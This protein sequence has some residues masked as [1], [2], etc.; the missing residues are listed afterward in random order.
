MKVR[1]PI[2]QS[3]PFMHRGGRTS[4]RIVCT[5][6]RSLDVTVLFLFV[7][8]YFTSVIFFGKSLLDWWDT[9]QLVSHFILGKAKRCSCV[10]GASQRSIFASS[11]IQLNY[12][13]LLDLSCACFVCLLFTIIWVSYVCGNCLIFGAVPFILSSSHLG[14][15][16]SLSLS[17]FSPSFSEVSC[18]DEEPR[19]SSCISCLLYIS[20]LCG[21]IFFAPIF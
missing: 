12:L 19:S 1:L 10:L 21:D 20:E 4:P 13:C 16:W 2:S 18:L 8:N 11:D 5:G 6:T 14:E 17:P 15:A 3:T 7:T 9:L